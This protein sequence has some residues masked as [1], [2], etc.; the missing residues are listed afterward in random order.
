MPGAIHS[1]CPLS[2]AATLKQ[3]A[4]HDNCVSDSTQKV[5]YPLSLE[6]VFCQLQHKCCTH[7]KSRLIEHHQL[8]FLRKVVNSPLVWPLHS[9]AGSY[10]RC[11][12]AQRS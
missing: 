8:K 7:T 11:Q 10:W 4:N 2:P 12:A 6:I 1:Q 3:M 9:P 5:A